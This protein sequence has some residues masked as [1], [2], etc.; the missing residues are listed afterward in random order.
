MLFV[1][2]C[3]QRARTVVNA[4]AIV[5]RGK[6][7]QMHVFS[8]RTVNTALKGINGCETNHTSLLKKNTENNLL[9]SLSRFA[10]QNFY[11][12]CL[13]LRVFTLAKVH[14]NCHCS[15]SVENNS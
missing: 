6:A 9:L 10:G 12:Y 4:G 2:C 14:P 8:G 5:D 1:N 3:I 7:N 11:W 13:V 15:F